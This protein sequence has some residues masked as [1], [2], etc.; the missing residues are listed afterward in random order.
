MNV[1]FS[2]MI[3]WILVYNG[4]CPTGLALAYTIV[5][6]VLWLGGSICKA[7]LDSRKD[8]KETWEEMAQLLK[9]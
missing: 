6:G 2:I 9:K 3:M 4:W 7:I 1:F 8:E 5:T